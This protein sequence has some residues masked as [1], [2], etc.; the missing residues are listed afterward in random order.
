M[1]VKICGITNTK[2]AVA[3]ALAGANF[4]GLNFASGPRKIDEAAAKEILGVLGDEVEPVALFV[5]AAPKAVAEVL[6]RLGIE[7]V[8]LHGSEPPE[9]VAELASEFKVIKVI[10]VAGPESLQEIPKYQPWAF[11]LDASSS[12]APGGT[13][14]TFDWSLVADAR[15][16][17]KIILAGGLTPDNVAE[18]VAQVKPFA[19]DVASGVE[20]APGAKDPELMSRFVM[21][22]T[23]VKVVRE[24][25]L[26]ELKV[27]VQT[28]GP[29]SDAR[30]RTIL[31]EGV[32]ITEKHIAHFEKLGVQS[33]RIVDYVA[34]EDAETDG[35][36]EGAAEAD[37]DTQELQASLEK[38]LE[39]TSDNAMAKALLEEAS[40]RFTAPR[41]WQ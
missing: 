4:V 16:F 24:V 38:F 33:I 2:D 41:T 23:H 35:S 40:K 13:G 12:K 30:G 18:A 19:V 17:G 15:E 32:E 37:V 31:G 36:A 21:N 39:G 20:S 27:G 11:L 8:Q 6:G 22:A 5:D 1:K 26:D 10:N 34:I 14:E 29:V 3:A 7:H 9:V 25:T 28:G